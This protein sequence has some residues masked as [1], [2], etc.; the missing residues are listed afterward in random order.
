MA[1]S[2]VGAAMASN[3]DSVINHQSVNNDLDKINGSGFD[4]NSLVSNNNND[5]SK[6]FIFE[7]E[8]VNA[9]NKASVK[10]S[11]NTPEISGDANQKAEIY[12]I[13][14]PANID[15]NSIHKIKEEN[16]KKYNQIIK[17]A[18]ENGARLGTKFGRVGGL[19]IGL[20]SGALLGSFVSPFIGT[21]IG[22]V[23]GAIAGMSFFEARGEDMGRTIAQDI[24][25]KSYS[26]LS[27][28]A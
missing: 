27:K 16:E 18:G 23:I 15:V 19:Y 22:G 3:V 12:R 2:N 13:S 4:A 17:E 1:V 11:T 20:S 24:V 9:D 10:V 26:G 6:Y 28:L 8:A 5:L 14:V 25:R 21:F 7:K